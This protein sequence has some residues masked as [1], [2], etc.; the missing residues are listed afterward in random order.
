[1][2]YKSSG[3]PSNHALI[4]RIV[5]P[6]ESVPLSREYIDDTP[7]SELGI[8]TADPVKLIVL[9]SASTKNVTS[10]APTAVPAS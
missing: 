7:L 6:E 4:S 1:M 8:M 9:A 3:Y 10:E 2:P 5:P